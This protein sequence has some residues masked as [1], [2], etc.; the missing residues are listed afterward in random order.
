MSKPDAL[1]AHDAKWTAQKLEIVDARPPEFSD[2]SLALRFSV[3]HAGDARYV[4]AW[5]KWLLWTGSHWQFDSTLRAFEMARFI[6]RVASAEITEPKAVKLAAAIASAKTVAAVASLARADRRHAATV[7]QW[8]AEP[9]LL[10]TPAGVVDLRTGARLPHDPGYHITKITAVAPGGD[11]PRWQKFLAEITNDDLE[12]QAFLQRVAGYSLTG[13][14]REHAL[15][16]AYGTG[17]NGK[18]VFLGTLI[19]ILASYAAVA[20]MSTF[21][22]SAAEQHP[23]DLAGLR[24]ARLVT[25]QETEQGRRWAESKVK[26]LTGGDPISARFM[27][28]DFFEYLPT[29]K[30]VIAGNHKPG[31]RGVDEAIRRRFYLIPFVV[32]IAEPDKELPDKLRAEW[33]GILQWAIEGCLQWQQL[34]LAPPA[35]VCNA[36][37]EYLA[38]EDAIAQWT[39]ECC[40]LDKT[41]S[42]RT[43]DLFASWKA[44]AEKAGEVVGTQKR[45]TQAFKDRGFAYDH[46][47]QSRR[48]IFR[49][50]ALLVGP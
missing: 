17:G 18:S 21:L 11:C 24:G 50:I 46:E 4:A 45:F 36:T 22:A 40:A 39:D 5:N 15:F 33:S 38:A 37:D 6:C 28:Q 14:I 31:L 29:F 43:A 8:D 47:S 26:A 7:D 19:G 49:G 32:T 23:T 10:N 44:W 35:A 13:S 41:Y 2:E 16:F 30:L 12:M 27:R 20:P 25:A 42:E 34:G 48:A 1:A 9:W 3:K